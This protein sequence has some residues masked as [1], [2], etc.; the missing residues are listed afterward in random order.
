MT[1]TDGSPQEPSRNE[2]A[3]DKI[4][5]A[6]IFLLSQRGF[7][8]ATM[9][10]IAKEAGVSMAAL[11]E[12]YPDRDAVV[13]AALHMQLPRSEFSD[14]GALDTDLRAWLGFLNARL[15]VPERTRLIATL[16]DEATRNPAIAQAL[17]EGVAG[18]LRDDL[19][20]VF[21]RAH[22]RG[23]IRPG[24]NLDVAIDIAV[25]PIYLRRL[26]SFRP[27]DDDFVDRLVE[28]LLAAVRAES[29]SD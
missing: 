14:T 7:A 12:R 23:E 25:A 1:V 19:R 21:E 2:I 4:L 8:G 24:V 3:D 17:H 10:A 26:E 28:L 5:F 13:I 16:L 18:P 11:S 20:A 27:A 6:V 22:T 15:R 29:A 9:L